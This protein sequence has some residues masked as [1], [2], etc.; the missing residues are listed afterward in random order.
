M[1]PLKI[2]KPQ[3]FIFKG[4]GIWSNNRDILNHLHI[5]FAFY[6]I[7][8][9]FLVT[10]ISS[11]LFVGSMKE[12]IDN[13]IVTN[14]TILAFLKG[15]VFYYK[16]SKHL[17]MLEIIKKHGKEI[18]LQSPIETKIMEK[19]HEIADILS[20]GFA[21]CYGFA[22]IFLAIQSIFGSS[23]QVFWTSTALLPG[24]INQNRTIYWI[25]F[26][27][28][29]F[30]NLVLVIATFACDTYGIIVTMILNSYIDILSTRLNILGNIEVKTEEANDSSQTSDASAE[31]IK[32]VK[33]F[34]TC[35]R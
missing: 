1:D 12:A 29:G 8:I 5:T 11:I 34:Y 18:N 16:Y 9:G 24:E 19:F 14:S 17:E 28:Q 22:W 21:A 20:H 15:I 31:L 4:F 25:V 35:L 6:F 13:L 27:F 2:L 7:S 30:S 23:E 10:L 3:A 26:G 32:C 33:T